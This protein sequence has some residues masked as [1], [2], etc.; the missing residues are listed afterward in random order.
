MRPEVLYLALEQQHK[1]FFR[2]AQFDCYM[3][4]V[5]SLGIVSR[6]SP[7]V[8]LCQGVLA[9]GSTRISGNDLCIQRFL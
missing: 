6:L 8:S 4:H 2:R 7:D 9:I 1:A 5:M 3:L